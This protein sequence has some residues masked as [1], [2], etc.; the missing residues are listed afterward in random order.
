MTTTAPETLDLQR[1]V[2]LRRGLTDRVR[3]IDV[4]TTA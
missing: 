4:F 2:S 1:A 3:L